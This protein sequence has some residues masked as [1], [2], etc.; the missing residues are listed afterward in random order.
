MY[1]RQNHYRAGVL[2]QEFY[3]TSQVINKYRFGLEI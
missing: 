3:F 1:D 2:T